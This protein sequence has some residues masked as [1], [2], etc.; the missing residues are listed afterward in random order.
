[1]DPVCLVLK[2]SYLPVQG[3]PLSPVGERH[4]C[5]ERKAGSWKEK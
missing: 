2:E 3:T 1:M 4:T 5:E